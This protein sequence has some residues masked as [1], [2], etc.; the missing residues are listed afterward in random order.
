M[1][2]RRSAVTGVASGVGAIGALALSA[3]GLLPPAGGDI[4]NALWN[5][6]CDAIAGIPGP[7]DIVL[8]KGGM[9]YVSSTDRWAVEHG[10]RPATADGR[11]GHL[12][13]INLTVEPPTVTDVT[14]EAFQ[15]RDFHPLGLSL[16]TVGSVR[17]LFVVDQHR[18]A[19]GGVM[20]CGG[21]TVDILTVDGDRLQPERPPIEDARQL[22]NPN[23]IAAVGPNAFYVTNSN[24]TGSCL[25]QKLGDLFD[26]TGGH[27]LYYDGTRFHRVDGDVPLANGIIADLAARRLFVASTLRGDIRSY[28]WEAG[29]PARPMAELAPIRTGVGVD[30]LR[31]LPD[32]SLLAAAHPNPLRFALYAAGW[33]DSAPT[34]I[35]RVVPDGPAGPEVIRIRD[36]DGGALSAASV[37]VLYDDGR[38]RRRLLIGA[39]YAN[40][41]L[42]CRPDTNGDS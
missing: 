7:E 27:V 12:F 37:A 36:D 22:R 35:L 2:R 10:T 31:Q 8:D 3:C 6:R 34:Q 18:P 13:R 5:W 30:N 40:H 17:R 23:S 21:T 38:G 25:G 1:G 16:F 24:D 9:A 11:P 29:H 15:A 28:S 42:L 33:T 14:P 32:G 4:R 41:V 19:G 20:L 26:V 39:T